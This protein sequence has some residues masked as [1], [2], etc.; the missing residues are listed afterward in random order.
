M[1]TAALITA[2]G[3]GTR[4]GANQPKAL[5]ALAGRPLVAYAAAAFVRAGITDLVVS[6]PAGYEASMRAALAPRVLTQAAHHAWP[7]AGADAGLP[8]YSVRVITG[9]A[10]RQD[11]VFAGLRAM[12][13][14]PPTAVFVHDA[15]RALTPPSLIASLWAALA[16]HRAV[17]PALAMTDTL[18]TVAHPPVGSE[19]V[20]V[21]DT[22]D[23][24]TTIAVQTP[25]A[26]DYQLLLRAH[27]HAERLAR[28]ATDDASLIA[29]L[30]EP[31]VAIAGSEQAFKITTPPDLARAS[32]LLAHGG[33][34][35]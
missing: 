32:A 30:G 6:A 3:A 22:V 31:V 2:A 24:A 16:N 7:R 11:S 25:Q 4:L 9:G 17:I 28:R 23:R 21:G 33:L 15:A 19:P 20:S 8:V 26:C 18:K 10:Q 34:C 27:R 5:V 14:D 12:G 29:A 35:S 13:D 1:R